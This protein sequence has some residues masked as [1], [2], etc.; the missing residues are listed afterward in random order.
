M[1]QKHP[2]GR[3]RRNKRLA[4]KFASKRF[5]DSYVDANVRRFLA[6]Q[7]R[8]LRGDLS[9]EEFGKQLG[10]PQ[11]VVSRYEDPTYGKFGLQTLLEIAAKTNRALVARFVDFPTFLHFTEDLSSRAVC[12]AGYDQNAVDRLALGLI[13]KPVIRTESDGAEASVLPTI[14]SDEDEDRYQLGVGT[15]EKWLTNRS[16]RTN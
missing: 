13:G 6:M 15:S 2:Y 7:M 1:E 8:A 10:I 11:S 14:S 16:V 3:S 4:E 5:R 12:P 9:Q